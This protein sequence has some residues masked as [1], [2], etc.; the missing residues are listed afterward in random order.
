MPRMFGYREV[1][2]DKAKDRLDR[3]LKSLEHHADRIA[4]AV[5]QA[6]AVTSKLDQIK[7][8]AREVVSGLHDVITERTEVRA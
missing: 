4:R 5:P 2:A 6:G 7:E 8:D 3:D 1:D